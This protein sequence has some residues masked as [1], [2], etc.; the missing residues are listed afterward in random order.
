MGRLEED[1]RRVLEPMIGGA[2]RDLQIAD[3]RLLAFRAFG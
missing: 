2:S 3:Q 1:V